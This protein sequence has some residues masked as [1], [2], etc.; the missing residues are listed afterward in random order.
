M[1]SKIVA[2]SSGELKLLEVVPP[3]FEAVRIPGAN[4]IV[5]SGIA[6]DILFQ[7]FQEMGFTIVYTCALLKRAETFTC[8][9]KE[10][11]PAL[12][13]N[14]VNSRLFDAGNRNEKMMHECAYNLYY[15]PGTQLNM[16]FRKPGYFESL[17]I[18]Y[19]NNYLERFISYYPVLSDFLQKVNQQQAVVL[20]KANQIAPMPMLDAIDNMLR[21]SEYNKHVLQVPNTSRGYDILAMAMQQA[22]L[23]PVARPVRF[24]DRE[25][26]GIYRTRDWL[27]KNLD[28]YIALQ[29]IA[30][31]AGVTVYKL[32]AGFKKVYGMPVFEYMRWHR[33]VKARKMLI[34][35]TLPMVQIASRIG[36]RNTV[37]FSAAFKECFHTT[38][39]SYRKK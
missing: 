10:T 9:G 39:G 6:G 1:F 8:F 22:T 29:Q 16:R 24:S 36:Y 18:Y 13:I 26:E 27:L 5:A 38:P 23:H 28:Q 17:S 14:L 21:L 7:E 12:H 25:I 34:N 30:A 19:T 32:Q 11:Q 35:T 37:T 31:N 3:V 2:R 20:W 33:M 4:F 15:V